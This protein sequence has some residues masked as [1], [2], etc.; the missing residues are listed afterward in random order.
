MKFKMNKKGMSGI[1]VGLN[2]A[3]LAIGVIGIA[4]AVV[5]GVASDATLNL[6]SLETLVLGF[7]GVILIAVFLARLTKDAK[8]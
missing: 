2:I 4:L 1:E 6:S 7:A 5:K 3:L 8:M